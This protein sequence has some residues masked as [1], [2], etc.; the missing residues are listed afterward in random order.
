MAPEG[1]TTNLGRAPLSTVLQEIQGLAAGYTNLELDLDSGER[2]VALSP[3]GRTFGC[4][5]RVLEATLVVNSHAAAVLLGL[6][7]IA[8]GREV[9]VS[10]GKLVEIG[11]ARIH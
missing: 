11:G 1:V 6:N 7:T 8:K 4:P 5:G 9:I 2:G 3:P 10:R